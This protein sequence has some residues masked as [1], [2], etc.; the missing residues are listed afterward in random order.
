MAGILRGEGCWSS[1][2]RLTPVALCRDYPPLPVCHSRFCILASARKWILSGGQPGKS[3]PSWG[4]SPSKGSAGFLTSQ[5]ICY[6]HDLHHVNGQHFSFSIHVG[7]F[8][9]LGGSSQQGT[10]MHGP[11]NQ[12][13]TS[14][15]VMIPCFCLCPAIPMVV[16]GRLPVRSWLEV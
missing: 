15:C 12:I 10:V 13:F 11:W 1:A 9:W 16:G 14:R 3:F 2:G 6:H 5:A 7:F 8:F 4:S